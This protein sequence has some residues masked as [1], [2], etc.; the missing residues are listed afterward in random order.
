MSAEK[1]RL[2][3]GFCAR[4]RIVDRG[5]PLFD[6]DGGGRVVA[7]RFGRD[8]RL[9]LRRS[10][11]MEDLLA[12][13]VERT[14]AAPASGPATLEGVLYLMHW[15]EPSGRVLPLYVWRAGRYGRGGGNVSA[16]LLA[17]CANA[18]K[19]ARWGSNYAYHIGD[20]S[21]ASCPGHAPVKLTPKY[22]RWAER[23]FL[24]APAPRPTLR[25]PVFFWATA[26]GPDSYSIWAEFGACS[27]AFE[28]YLLIGVASELF[29]DVLLNDEAVN[30]AGPPADVPL[31]VD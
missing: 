13:E 26:W 21:A 29:P 6:A 31:A 14:V 11:A 8:G 18:G 9:V 17:I 27:L 19:F 2:W 5:V 10:A 24:D 7:E 3:D 22:R 20:L 1:L 23:L 25:R 12:A 16:N 28:E 4:H 15:R 30:R